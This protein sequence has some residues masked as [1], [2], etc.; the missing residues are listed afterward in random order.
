VIQAVLL[1][2][3][4]ADAVEHH[5]VLARLDH[6]EHRVTAVRRRRL[7]HHH[8]NPVGPQVPGQQVGNFE[9]DDR[10]ADPI[11]GEAAS[12]PPRGVL[13]GPSKYS[14]QLVDAERE[15]VSDPPGHRRLFLLVAVHT[16]REA[17]RPRIG[18][19]GPAPMCTSGQ[20]RRP[21]S[22]GISPR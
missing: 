20:G 4:D 21:A 14:A 7:S 18:Q 6:L 11:R 2:L 15:G 19:V 22:A 3:K 8:A 12:E 16:S 17:R 10:L 5:V 13:C 1:K 9:D